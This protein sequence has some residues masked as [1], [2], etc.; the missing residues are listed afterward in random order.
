MGRSHSGSGLLPMFGTVCIIFFFSVWLP[1]LFCVA[2]G[3]AE[4]GRGGS[5]CLLTHGY[6]STL[7]L[8]FHRQDLL[9]HNLLRFTVTVAAGLPTQT[10]V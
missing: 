4:V 6:L 1:N 9:G 3:R 7:G 2:A 8:S 5:P 10:L